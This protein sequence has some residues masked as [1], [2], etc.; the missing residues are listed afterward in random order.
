MKKRKTA[1]V[2]V[3]VIIGI[4]LL[5]A[6]VFFLYQS[7]KQQEIIL[8]D[9]NEHEL[10]VKLKEYLMTCTQH[11]TD[12]QLGMATQQGGYIQAMPF[13]SVFYDGSFYALSFDRDG[14]GNIAS[15]EQIAEELAQVVPDEIGTCLTN[16]VEADPSLAQYTIDIFVSEIS[17][18]AATDKIILAY[19]YQFNIDDETYSGLIQQAVQAPIYNLIARVDEI[20]DAIID[21]Y[22]EPDILLNMQVCTALSGTQGV[23]PQYPVD[24]L[25]VLSPEE[26]GAVIFQDDF[27]IVTFTQDQFSFP[28]AV[29]P[30]LVGSIC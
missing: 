26:S 6:V 22:T 7:S 20:T 3:F 11:V 28:F 18:I 12:T 13:E 25:K 24:F 23:R 30:P 14:Q 16:T 21:S 15:K 19:D 2:T 9:E 1:Q 29:K 5:A 27:F 8:E 17:G 10:E 4:I